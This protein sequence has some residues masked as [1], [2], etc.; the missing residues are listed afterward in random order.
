MDLSISTSEL[1][2]E[3]EIYSVVWQ[4]APAS[5]YQLVSCEISPKCLLGISTLEDIRAIDAY[6]LCDSF[7]SILFSN[8]LSIF[9]Y[10]YAHIFIFSVFQ[11]N[12]F[13]E[14]FGFGKSAI[15]LCSN[16]RLKHAFG[17]WLLRFVHLL[18]GLRELKGELNF[19]LSF[20]LLCCL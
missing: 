3:S 14:F 16:P 13:S 15:R 4:V 19:L 2:T 20:P 17:F 9:V 1:R 12:I 6:I 7:C 18:L 5:K 11:W 10:L 8:S